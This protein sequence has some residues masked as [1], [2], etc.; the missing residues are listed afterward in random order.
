MGV[1]GGECEHLRWEETG[2]VV[3]A[4]VDEEWG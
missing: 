4:G 1:V 3:E 2:E